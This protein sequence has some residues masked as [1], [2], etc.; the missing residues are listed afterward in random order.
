MMA[1]SIKNG[2]IFPKTHQKIDH[3]GDNITLSDYVFSVDSPNESKA[4]IGKMLH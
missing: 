1:L 3:I 2:K 4:D